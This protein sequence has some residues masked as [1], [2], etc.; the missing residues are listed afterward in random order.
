MLEFINV[1]VL[2]FAFLV[3]CNVRNEAVGLNS[4]LAM[5]LNGVFLLQGSYLWFGLSQQIKN[6]TISN[7]ANTFKRLKLI[8]LALVIGSA[9]IILFYPSKGNWD[10]YGA[11][12]FLL[13]AMLEYINYFEI[14]LMYDNKNDL[15]YVRKFGRLKEAK[16]KRLLL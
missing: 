13:L 14:Q 5:T 3:N 9:I 16:V 10:K 8:D 12:A 11:I 6:K 15:N 2:P 4:I 7:L 1:F